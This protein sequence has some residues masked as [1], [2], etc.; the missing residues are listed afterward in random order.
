[1]D[2]AVAVRAIERVGDLDRVAD[3]SLGRQRAACE[4][5]G[6]RLALEELHDQV[7]DAVLLAE[8]VQDADVRMVQRADDAGFAIEAL[9]EL[10]VGGELRRQDLDRDVR[11]RRV[12]TAR[13]TCPMPPAAT[14]ATTS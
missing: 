12:S 8:V 5:R 14:G 7:G 13:Y 10:R 4:P 9:A 3:T 11:S 1:M 2:H 6:Q